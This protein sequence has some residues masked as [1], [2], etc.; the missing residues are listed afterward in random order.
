M[1]VPPTWPVP[2]PERPNPFAPPADSP[3]DAD[4]DPQSPYG[5]GYAPPSPSGYEAASTPSPSW[6]PGPEAGYG[7][8][9]GPPPGYGYPP[10]VWGS[11]QPPVDGLAIASI[12]TSGAGIFV[13]GATGLVGIGLG[14]ASLSRIRRTGARGRGLAWGGIAI[15]IAMTL[16]LGAF[17]AFVAA[18]A[19][20][21]SHSSA[22]TA[23]RSTSSRSS[24][25]STDVASDT[26]LR[27]G[28]CLETIPAT[29]LKDVV[30]IDCAAPHIAEVLSRIAF[31]AP[32]NTSVATFDTAWTACISQV[33]SLAPAALAATVVSP[34]L[35][36]P[37]DVEWAS[38]T[39]TGYCM[40]LGTGPMTGS[41]L[42][43]TLR[44]DSSPVTT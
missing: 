7:S 18:S 35:W 27:P 43:G 40:L 14:I 41:A 19:S 2:E 28:Q 17:I 36:G 23:L 38:G 26:M 24:E 34:D 13:F 42:G 32:P 16:L 33:D 39:R 11:S 37:S 30:I 20:F 1:S 5:P 22:S 4:S 25:P 10:P 21:S 31:T 3:H 15:G 6:Q 9:Q 8:P 29:E 44:V 12:A